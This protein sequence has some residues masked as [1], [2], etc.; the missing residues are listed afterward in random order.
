MGSDGLRE[1]K[2]VEIVSTPK[3]GRS[4]RGDSGEKEGNEVRDLSEGAMEEAELD[5]YDVRRL[6]GR[7]VPER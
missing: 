7:T 2:K 6:R 5:G 4:S 1:D 3:K